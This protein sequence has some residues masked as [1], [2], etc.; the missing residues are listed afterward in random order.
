MSIDL[1]SPH[2]IDWW[3]FALKLWF[4]SFTLT[5]IW[6]ILFRFL[7]IIFEK[8]YSLKSIFSMSKVRF[9]IISKIYFMHSIWPDYDITMDW[10][11]TKSG[12]EIWSRQ[13]HHIFKQ[14]ITHQLL[15]LGFACVKIENSHIS[16]IIYKKKS[17]TILRTENQ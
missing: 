2:T 17:N 1:W 11:P 8:L 5:Y 13:G 14:Y 4:L 9:K 3:M 7:T 12:K 10:I 6:Q 16:E 15:K